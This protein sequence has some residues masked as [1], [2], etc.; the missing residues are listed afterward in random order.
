MV[1]L[2]DAALIPWRVKLVKQQLNGKEHTVVKTNASTEDLRAEALRMK[3][4]LGYEVQAD[5]RLGRYIATHSFF[6]GKFV[7][8]LEQD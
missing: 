1:A 8:M 3:N 4:Q 5:E 7:L 6:R 2:C